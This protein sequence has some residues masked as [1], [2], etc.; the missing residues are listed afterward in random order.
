MN[1]ELVKLVNVTEEHKQMIYNWRNQNHIRKVM[2][3]SDFISWESHS[4]WIKN[5]LKEENRI[6]KVLYY[7]QIPYGIANFYKLDEKASVGEWGFYIGEKSAP[8]GMGKLLAYSML[9]FLFEEQGIR[10]VCAEVIEFNDIS[11]NFHKKIGF[12]LDGVLRQ[13][14]LKEARYQDVYLFSI[15]YDEWLKQR[16]Q[17]EYE[18]FN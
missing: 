14:I 1:R 3:H 15:F 5:I 10:K 13:H 8:K 6:L 9:N 4:T 2:Y 11:L 17:L 7:N 16:L 18:L 12:T